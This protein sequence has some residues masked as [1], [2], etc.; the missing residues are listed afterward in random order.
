LVSRGSFIRFRFA[1][2]APVL[3]GILLAGAVPTAAVRAQDTGLAAEQTAIEAG[4]DLTARGKKTLLRA[5]NRQD[6]GDNA[7]AVELMTEWLN[8]DPARD[9][10]L[11]RFNLALSHL[12]LEQTGPAYENLERAVELQPRFGRAWLRLGEAAY[13]LD[14]FAAAGRAFLAAYDLTPA[15]T[16]EILY[17]AGVTLLMGDESAAALPPLE[18]LLTD[19]RDRAELDW[20]QALIAAATGADRPARARP[21]LD[22]LLEDNP[23]EPRAWDLA[24]QFAAGQE[25]YRSAA[26]FLTIA[27]YLRPLSRA[28]T[29]QLGDLYAVI[30]VPV[31]AARYYEQAM[32]QP[33]GQA[34]VES[35]RAGEYLRLA[36]AWMSAHRHENARATLKQALGEKET[37]RLWALLGDLEYLDEDYAAALEAFTRAG[38]IDPAFGRGWLMMG[39]CAIELGNDAAAR[40][41]LTR[42]TDFSDQAAAARSLL[43]RLDR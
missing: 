23:A 12:A 29:F 35:G 1:G 33:A 11:L 34:S 39:Y 26:V 15:P 36:T 30:D 3:A 22:R 14:R 21:F 19:Y 9:H 17:Y 10:H 40:E 18:K 2:L 24:Y 13:E 37:R 25:D 42:A 38:N 43:E 28:E 7:G 6:A 16:P 31:K 4:D 27:G 32:A 20:Y 41:H 5:R 8:S